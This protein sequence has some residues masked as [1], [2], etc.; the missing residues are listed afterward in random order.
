MLQMLFKPYF[1]AFILNST[2]VRVAKY[3]MHEMSP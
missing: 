1:Q 2:L 3:Q